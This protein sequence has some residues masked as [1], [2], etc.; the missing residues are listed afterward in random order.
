MGKVK[1]KKKI[2]EICICFFVMLAGSI[3]MEIVLQDSGIW[4]G[5]LFYLLLGAL[6][7]FYVWKIERAPL[8]SVG[9]QKIC[10]RDIGGGL[11]LGTCMFVVQQIPLFLM[12]MDYSIYAMPPDAVYIVVMLLYCL[13][14][15]GFVEELVFRGFIFQRTQEV[16]S[17]PAVSI[18]INI[19]LFYA[20]HWSSVPLSFGG[21][22]SIA[23]NVVLLSIYL[24]KSRKKSIVPLIIAHGFYDI[25]TSVILPVVVFLFY[26]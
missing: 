13:I 1:K 3:F 24:L 10:L 5:V 15:V 25:L 26:S 9:L 11:L 17:S 4:A 22:Y 7:I 2:L 21:L 19:L 16:C 20:I 14:C 8:S 23:V 12:K 18:G 6:L